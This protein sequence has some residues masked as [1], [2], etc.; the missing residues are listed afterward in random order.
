MAESVSSEK[1]LE[2]RVTEGPNVWIAAGDGDIERVKFLLEH[3]NVTPTSGD[4]AGYTPIH[5]AVSYAQHELLRF[6][7]EHKSAGDDAVNIRDSDDESPL[8]FCEDVS[9]AKIL[10][11]F[12][13]DTKLKNKDGLTAAENAEVN[14]WHDVAVFLWD[15][16]GEEPVPRQELLKRVGEE[17][18]EE[19]VPVQ[20]DGEDG[21]Q[22]TEQE[23][24]ELDTRM[25]EMLSRVEEIMP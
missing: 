7:L 25:E 22:I 17:E 21:N 14:D 19:A 1:E 15:S 16:S 9:T 4:S 20:Q 8:F 23:D 5:A 12:G 24:E 18:D 11:E 10:L 3:G 6:L 2:Q 13:A